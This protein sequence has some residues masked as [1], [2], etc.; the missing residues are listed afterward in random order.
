MSKD[1][2][3]SGNIAIIQFVI[4][5]ILI[6]NSEFI[7]VDQMEAQDGAPTPPELPPPPPNFWVMIF[8]IIAIQNLPI[9]K[10]MYNYTY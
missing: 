5:W 8:F 3:Q 2:N 7:L 10:A 9:Y 4:L 6:N 1:N